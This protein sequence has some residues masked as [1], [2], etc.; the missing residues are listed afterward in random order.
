MN[1]TYTLKEISTDIVSVAEA[2]AFLRLEE[3]AEDAFVSICIESAISYINN[4]LGY[5]ITPRTMQLQ[6]SGNDGSAVKL[7]YCEGSADVVTINNVLD[8]AGQPVAYTFADGCITVSADVAAYSA[9]YTITP[10]ITDKLHIKQAA[11]LLVGK[12]FEQRGDDGKA[13]TE[14]GWETIDRLLSL[15][16]LIWV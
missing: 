3:D 15:V 13:L 8:A 9:E 7:E 2:K 10:Q 12:Y 6:A 16:G 1:T 4:R 14:G 5:C 11:L